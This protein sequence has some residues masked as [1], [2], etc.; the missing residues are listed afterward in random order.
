MLRFCALLGIGAML[1]VPM[2]ALAANYD[3]V[4]D[5]VKS[6]ITIAQFAGAGSSPL[7]GTYSLDLG[8]PSGA[9][10][11][12]SWNVSAALDTISTV[13]TQDV[14]ITVV[15]PGPT[16]YSLAVAAGGFGLTDWNSDKLA[17]PST[18][19]A[20]GP[21]ISDGAIDTDA[22]KN[23]SYSVDNIPYPVDTAWT[24]MDAPG[25]SIQVSDDGHLGVAGVGPVE[26]HIHA[27][28]LGN[29]SILYTIDLW[30]RAVPEPGMLSLVGAAG[31][32]LLRRRVR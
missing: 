11:N 5:P 22:H 9:Y 8:D 17:I 2:A 31:L 32:V 16:F 13:N 23:I 30:G 3:F 15:G 4:I 24:K 27:Q 20:N 10:P 26:S 28:V 29:L 25:W 18:T 7:S 12:R 1:A 6:S 19:L 14:T 21:P